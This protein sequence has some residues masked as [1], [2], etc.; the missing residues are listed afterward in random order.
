[1]T[2]SVFFSGASGVSPAATSLGSTATARD[3]DVDFF[4]PLT[5]LLTYLLTFFLSFF[6]SFVRSFVLPF[7]L[8]LSLSLR[9]S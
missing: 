9:L 1:V 3:G 8:S 6:L 7:P 5:Y 2:P 4:S